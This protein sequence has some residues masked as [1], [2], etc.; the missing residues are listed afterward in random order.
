MKP[1]R[2]ILDS[3]ILKE[4]SVVLSKKELRHFKVLRLNYGDEII[5]SDGKGREFLANVV[6]V[7]RQ[8]VALELLKEYST[9]VDKL[10]NVVL[11]QGLTKGT[12]L[13]LVIQ[14]TTELGVSKIVPMYSEYSQVK[15]KKD[16]EHKLN[17]WQEIARQAV[18]QSGRNYLPEI[19]LYKSFKDS[20]LEA[21][22]FD[23]AIICCEPGHSAKSLKEV[24][25]KSNNK[26]KRMGLEIKNLGIFIGPEGGFSS[27][28]VAFAKQQGII[29]VSLGECALRS[30]TAGIVSIGLAL[31]LWGNLGN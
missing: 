29:P 8:Q 12:K 5:V 15:P 6:K 19:T 18:R 20:V 16:R 27:L 1:P 30:E 24:F 23:L 7:D 13:E 28:E 21:K 11:Y 25:K 17:R 3:E 9:P 31:Y 26:T 2:F 14:K 4:K 10:L 22:Q